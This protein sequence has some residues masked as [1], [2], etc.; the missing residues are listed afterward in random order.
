MQRQMLAM[1]AIRDMYQGGQELRSFYVQHKM[2]GGSDSEVRSKG[3]LAFLRLDQDPQAQHATTPSVDIWRRKGKE[4]QGFSLPKR[5]VGSGSHFGSALGPNS[6]GSGVL[7]P[8]V[9][10][11]VCFW[12]KSCVCFWE[13][14]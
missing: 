2:V 11:C 1:Q 4:L 3:L 12:V 5:E 8:E 14:S 9:K 13:G 10:S 6:G 7:G